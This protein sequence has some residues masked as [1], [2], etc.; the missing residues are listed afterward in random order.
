MGI[1]NPLSATGIAANIPGA[2]VVDAVEAALM[3][4]VAAIPGASA[5][6]A[7][8]LPSG[9]A[10]GANGASGSPAG[11]VNS[12]NSGAPSQ[13]ATNSQTQAFLAVLASVIDYASMYITEHQ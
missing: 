10:A 13:N 4:A 9:Q 5:V 3:P 6:A 8:L 12:L 2:G 7:S 1:S 11:T